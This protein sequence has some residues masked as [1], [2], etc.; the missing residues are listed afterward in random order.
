MLSHR[1]SADKVILND[2]LRSSSKAPVVCV[3]TV[4]LMT[5]KHSTQSVSFNFL[6]SIWLYPLPVPLSVS[7]DS[8][9]LSCQVS[10]QVLLFLQMCYKLFSHDFHW[11]FREVLL[12]S[13]GNRLGWEQQIGGREPTR[14]LFWESRLEIMKTWTRVVEMVSW[15]WKKWIRRN[16]PEIKTK[17]SSDPSIWSLWHCFHFL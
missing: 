6:K 14:R 17:V 13:W 12:L 4:T 7:K 9:P 5:L 8:T 16:D 11:I 1:C 15:K 3:S 2:F 10:I